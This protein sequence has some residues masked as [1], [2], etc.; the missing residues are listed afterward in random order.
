MERLERT[1]LNIHLLVLI[2]GDTGVVV[3][4]AALVLTKYLG[5][6]CFVMFNHVNNWFCNITFA[7][8]IGP[9]FYCLCLSMENEGEPKI[10]STDKR[11]QPH[12]NYL[13]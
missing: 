1:E 5:K 7:K 2:L 6:F 9:S 13:T 11:I 4:D 8:Y 12:P 3:W 10:K